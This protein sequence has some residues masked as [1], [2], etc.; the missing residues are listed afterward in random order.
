MAD[1]INRNSDIRLRAESDTLF[2]RVMACILTGNTYAHLKNFAME[3]TESGLRLTPSYDLFAAACYPPY[4]T[5]A[6]GMGGAE[7]LRIGGIGPKNIVRLGTLFGLPESAIMLAI[8]DFAR[9]L[10]SAH[11]AVDA[12]KNIDQSIK[13]KLHRQMEKRWNGI[14]D[15]IGNYLSKRR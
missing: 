10:D 2:C 14:F 6:L 5:L 8:S 13:D 12:P 7:N 15:S 3:H 4:Q 11:G 9:C 1:F